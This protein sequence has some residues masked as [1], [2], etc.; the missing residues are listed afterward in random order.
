MSTF[1]D[2]AIEVLKKSNKPMRPKAI[3]EKIVEDNLYQSSGKTPW[4]SL[5]TEIIASCIGVQCSKSYAEKNFYRAEPG[6]YGLLE[7]LSIE[8]K[9]AIEEESKQL[10]SSKS[11]WFVGAYGNGEDLTKEFIDEGVWRNGHED[12]YLEL[13][14]SMQSG[15]KIAI[16][17]SYT[18]KKNLPFDNKGQT[19]SVMGIKAIGTIVT[20]HKDGQVLD[21]EWEDHYDTPREW[22]FSTI[23]NT[24]KRVVPDDWATDNLIDFTFNFEE[25]DIQRF[26]NAPFWQERFGESNI[27]N[28]K[29]QWTKLYEQIADKI[30]IYKDNRL[31]LIKLTKELGQKF[32]LSYINN[33]DIDDICPF[34]FF[35]IFNRGIKHE[36]RIGIVKKIAEALNISEELPGDFDGIP[37]LNNQKSWF[38]GYPQDRGSDDIDNLWNFLSVALDFSESDAQDAREK[39]IK[40]YNQVAE[41]LCVGW[42]LTMALYWVRPWSFVTL[43]RQS[44]VYISKKLDIE[45]GNHGPQRRCSGQDYLNILEE[46]ELRLKEDAYPVHSF[47]ELSLAAWNYNEIPDVKESTAFEE[48]DQ[49]EDNDL[50]ARIKHY[51]LNNIIEEGAFIEKKQLESILNRIR[52]KKNIILQGPPGTGKTWLAKKLAFALIGEVNEHK[53]CTVQFHPNLSYE[54]FIRGWRPSGD[55]KLTLLDGPFLELVNEAKRDPSSKYVVVIEEINRGNPARVF[56]EMLTLLE[57]DKRTPN[58]ALELCYRKIKGEKIFIP[59]NLFVI[60]TMNIADR[61]LAIVDLALRRR[62]AFINLEPSFGESWLKWV[63]EKSNIPIEVLQ[64]FQSRIIT[65]NKMIA[66]DSSL[67]PQY[68]IG[69]SYLTPAFNTVINDPY[70]WFIQVV[71]T[72]IASLLEEYWFDNLDLAYKATN[73]LLAGI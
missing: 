23:R 59:D 37:I 42:N 49:D 18:R 20:N 24:I 58:E 51:S 73:L 3:W 57:A 41:Q 11:F 14:K 2:A 39:F 40:S 6:H 48:P 8:E 64:K 10:S 38:F 55:G 9:N 52:N 1:R 29:F 22:Y 60:G 68:K 44:R 12:K 53:I 46:L 32:S 17:S 61:S 47:P 7:W 33:Q 63:N 34:T 21:V 72:E 4:E 31:P 28:K 26:C 35:G 13:V 70:E 66:E 16:K 71:E 62:F 65:L 69:H 45:I 19:V 36:N 30:L 50:E 27:V 67:G 56:G 54:D 15:D 5:K 43:D 25:Q